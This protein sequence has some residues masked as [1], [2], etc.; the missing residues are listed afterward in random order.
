M[1]NKYL[2]YILSFAI[3]FCNI[4]IGETFKFETKNLE[5]LKD[6]NQILAGKGRAVSSDNDLEINA[7]K[8]EYFKNLDLLKSK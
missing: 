8:F 6:K 5:I 2:F 4:A 3:L 1:K 7:D